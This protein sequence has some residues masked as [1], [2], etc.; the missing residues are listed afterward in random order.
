LPCQ[1]KRLQGG[2]PTKSLIKNKTLVGRRYHE[3]AHADYACNTLAIV[4]AALLCVGQSDKAN[5]NIQKIEQALNE[6]QKKDVLWRY[7]RGEELRGKRRKIIDII[8]AME[9]SDDFISEVKKANA[10]TKRFNQNFSE[11]VYSSP[12]AIS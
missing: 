2:L 10:R 9:P 12:L 7:E 11:N 8:Y 3:V 4:F 1:P 5:E 6:L